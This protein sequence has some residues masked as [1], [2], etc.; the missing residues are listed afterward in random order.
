MADQLATYQQLNNTESANP[1]KDGASADVAIVVVDG[2]DAKKVAAPGAGDEEKGN[3]SDAPLNLSM[4]DEEKVIRLG[5]II[6]NYKQWLKDNPREVYCTAEMTLLSV[7]LVSQTFE[8][9]DYFLLFF[10]FVLC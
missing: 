1:A 10:H 5:Q 6:P 7:E 9:R 3:E 2:Q 4:D 8:L